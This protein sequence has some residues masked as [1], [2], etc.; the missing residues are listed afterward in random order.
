MFRLGSSG[1]PGDDLLAGQDPVAARC[2]ARRCRG[3][4]GRA[5]AIEMPL[6]AFSL[7]VL[8]S[9]SAPPT[10]LPSA[11]NAPDST[12]MPEPPLWLAMLFRDDHVDAVAELDAGLQRV[13]DVVVLDD[14]AVRARGVD[15]RRVVAQ[16]A[17]L[18]RAVV[19]V[20]EDDAAVRLLVGQDAVDLDPVRV[21]HDDAGVAVPDE[22][23]AADDR[24]RAIPGG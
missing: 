11:S 6:S 20:R 3:S 17:V 8:P 22:H 5:T 21:L 1:S 4:C 23:A 12:E 7:A 24:S 15:A 10:A 16:V 9:I 13:R 2:C 14:Q 19:G 18:D